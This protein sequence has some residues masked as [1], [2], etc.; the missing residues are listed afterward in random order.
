MGASRGDDM[1]RYQ[2]STIDEVAC[3]ECER[4]RS[5]RDSFKERYMNL[6][7]L[8]EA[9][10]RSAGLEG[11]VT[12]LSWVIRCLLARDESERGSMREWPMLDI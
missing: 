12:A 9:N 8:T 11:A 2:D 4:L 7:E 5:E 3:S 10:D 6:A 1:R